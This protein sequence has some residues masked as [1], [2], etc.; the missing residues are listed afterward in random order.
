M[1]SFQHGELLELTKKQKGIALY[2]KENEVKKSIF[3]MLLVVFMQFSIHAD[4]GILNVE[5]QFNVK[6]TADR[7][8]AILEKKGM[9]IFNRIKHSESAAKIGIQINE[10]E[11][12]IFGNPKAGSPLMKCQPT[13]AIDLPQ[14]AIIWQDKNNKVWLSYNDIRSLQKR[15]KVVNYEKVLLKVEKTLSNVVKLATSEKL[16]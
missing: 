3:I 9:T 13:M 10:T 5:S 4:D 15:H 12:I 7:L 16:P 6:T 1:L 2:Q 11:L 8:Q 14:K